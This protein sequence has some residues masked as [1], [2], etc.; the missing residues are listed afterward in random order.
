M[1]YPLESCG[2]HTLHCAHAHA[3]TRKR[4]YILTLARVLTHASA[5]TNLRKRPLKHALEF[6]IK[7]S[8]VCMPSKSRTDTRIP[9]YTTKAE[10]SVSTPT[11]TVRI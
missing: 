3:N 11:Y 9:A 8:Q 1:Y 5:R 2:A 6:T 4:T 7:N 10:T